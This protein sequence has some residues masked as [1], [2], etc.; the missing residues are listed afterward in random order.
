M[1]TSTIFICFMLLVMAIAFYMLVKSLSKAQ[2][3]LDRIINS[4]NRSLARTTERQYADTEPHHDPFRTSMEFH[5]ATD[6]M[7]MDD[8]FDGRGDLTQEQIETIGLIFDGY[9][10]DIAQASKYAIGATPQLAAGESYSHSIFAEENIIEG[11]LPTPRDSDV[12]K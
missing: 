8:R 1:D 11:I 4:R 12:A 3:K 6:V 2:S 5:R 7:E 9:R 10:P